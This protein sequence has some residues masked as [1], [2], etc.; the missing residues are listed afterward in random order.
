MH[1][2]FFILFNKLPTCLHL[3]HIAC[4][5]EYT[6]ASF[7]EAEKTL[8]FST[9]HCIKFNLISLENGKIAISG[10]LAWTYRGQQ[11]AI[12]VLKCIQNA[13]LWLQ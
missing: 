11:I 9:L 5:T 10:S 12:R 13:D 7:C 6:Q 2:I 4:L 1:D 8:L 3:L